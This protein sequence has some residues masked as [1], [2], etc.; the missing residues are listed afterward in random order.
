MFF[1]NESSEEFSNFNL[2][3]CGLM[4]PMDEDKKKNNFIF[5]L[6]MLI[7]NLDPKIIQKILFYN[8]SNSKNLDSLEKLLK[9]IG[10]Q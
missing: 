10:N 6:F 4:N 3:N 5:N 1:S 8:N 2:E 9:F 7:S